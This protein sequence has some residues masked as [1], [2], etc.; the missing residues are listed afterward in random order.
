ML[1]RND[2]ILEIFLNS[3]MCTNASFLSPININFNTYL[4]NLIIKLTRCRIFTERTASLHTLIYLKPYLHPKLTAVSGRRDMI[5]CYGVGTPGDRCLRKL[6]DSAWLLE[7]CYPSSCSP[8]ILVPMKSS[9]KFRDRVSHECLP[10]ESSIRSTFFQSL[11]IVIRRILYA[12]I[13]YY[14][15]DRY[16]RKWSLI[17]A[18]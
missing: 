13:A 16:L 12:R 15:H 17:I 3:S 10:H 4:P 8:N 5:S 7:K 6:V 9:P 18:I 11:K 2:R 14:T 1:S